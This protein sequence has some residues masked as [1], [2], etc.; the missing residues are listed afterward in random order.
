MLPPQAVLHTTLR[1]DRIDVVALPPFR[2]ASGARTVIDVAATSNER[3]LLA[4]IGSAIRDGWTSERFLRRRFA[5]LGGPGRHG[6]ALLAQ[7]LGEPVGHSALERRFLQLVAR[8]GL[9]RP[10]TQR[11]FHGERT[12]RVDVIWERQRLLVEV[13]GHRFHCT[14]LDLQRDAQ[15]R[16]ELQAMGY[17][18]LEFTAGDIVRE[19]RRTLS[20]V[21]RHLNSAPV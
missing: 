21:R 6:A 19:G 8:G 5:A 10:T 7:V 17:V 18:V 15:R 13:M 14:A 20:T 16:N 2:V 12:I 11:T 1:H 4:A 9:P 3:E